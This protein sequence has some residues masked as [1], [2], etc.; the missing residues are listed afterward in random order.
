MTAF[1]RGQG[2]A[3]ALVEAGSGLS[4]TYAELDSESERV[5]DALGSAP[6]LVF[7]F[8]AN[9]LDSAVTFLGARTG[10]HAIA[11]VDPGLRPE[12]VTRLV[13]LYEP[14][15]ITGRETLEDA[16][17]CQVGAGHWRRNTS[18]KSTV[19][20]DLAV[21]LSTSGSTGSPKFVRLSG[22]S[23]EHNACAIA[24]S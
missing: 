11:L 5:A 23:V 21:L 12:H 18:S 20:R 1:A 14:Q 24:K 8:A 16:L 2:N 13:A 4:L 9:S 19:H 15:H 17:Y 22:S 6:S 3:T 7:H 10:G